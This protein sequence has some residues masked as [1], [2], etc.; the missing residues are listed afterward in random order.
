MLGVDLNNYAQISYLFTPQVM[1]FLS[2]YHVPGTVLGDRD[3][4][5]NPCFYGA[6]VL[7]G[8][9]IISEAK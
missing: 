9:Q 1:N 6:Y 5:N 4:S 3:I 8:R 2:T 7:V